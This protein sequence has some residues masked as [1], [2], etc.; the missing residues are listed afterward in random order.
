MRRRKESVVSP[1]I[2]LFGLL[3]VVS[4][5]APTRGGTFTQIVAFG[6]SLSDAGN[7]SIASG[8]IQPGPGYVD[9]RYSDGPVWVE[10]LAGK[11][12]VA[13]PSPS[14]LGG[15]GHAWGGA[16][17]GLSGNSKLNTPNL[18]TQVGGY[19]STSPTLGADTLLTVWAGANDFL[20]GGQTD[21]TVSVSNVAA[22]IT[23]LAG[24][25][26][27]QFLVANLPMLGAI[28]ATSGL[29]QAQ[30]D[31]LNYLSYAY[32]ALLKAKVGELEQSLGIT[33]RY[34]DIDHYLQQMVANPS[35][36][37][38]TNVTDEM[39]KSGATDGYLFWDDVHPTTQVHGLIADLAYDAVVP[40][41]SS[42]VLLGIA[43]VAIA[44]GA[45]FHQRRAA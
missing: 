3:A 39:R 13:T 20:Y 1:K 5:G 8:G 33:I 32:N 28:P 2:V 41:P 23:T 31:G 27:S 29:P 38:L 25:G 11:L 7:V 10:H 19:L 17:T 34:L 43:G 35:A 9:G 37:G 36:F 44:A 45:G 21:P 26:G 40:E 14:L 22:A 6:D 24:A 18:G 12:G 16:E 15:T 42:I 30:R 4:L